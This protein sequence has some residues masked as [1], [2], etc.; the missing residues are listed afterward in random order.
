[1]LTGAVN[2]TDESTTMSRI[3]SNRRPLG[4]CF[5]TIRNTLRGMEK[6]DSVLSARF[7]GGSDSATKKM[8]Q[9]KEKSEMLNMRMKQARKPNSSKNLPF[10]K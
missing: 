10:E 1:M 4:R 5:F 6:K 8:H 2:P 7:S 3:S 9:T